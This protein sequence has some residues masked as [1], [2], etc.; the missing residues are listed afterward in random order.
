MGRRRTP[1]VIAQDVTVHLEP[2]L[3]A[4]YQCSHTR[5]ADCVMGAIAKDNPDIVAGAFLSIST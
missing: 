3:T 2:E 4:G 1:S 5:R